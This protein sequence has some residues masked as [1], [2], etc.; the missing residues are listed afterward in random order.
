MQVMAF[1]TPN[2]GQSADLD[3]DRFVTVDEVT[4]AVNA[5]FERLLSLN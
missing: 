2:G 3:S 4:R 5:A 1:W